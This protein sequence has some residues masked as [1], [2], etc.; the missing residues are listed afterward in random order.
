M[1]G[2]MRVE[3]ASGPAGGAYTKGD[4]FGPDRDTAVAEQCVAESHVMGF[5][6]FK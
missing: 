6:E 3:F 1:Y 2:A 5:P 4:Q